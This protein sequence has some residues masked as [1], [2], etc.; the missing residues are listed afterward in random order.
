VLL[1]WYGLSRGLAPLKALQQ[2]IRDRSPDDLSPIDAKAAPEEIA[3]LVDA[4]NDLLERLSENVGAQKRFIA[5]A[6]HQLK[7]PLA[8]LRT[9]SELALREGDPSELR[10]AL[11]QIARGSSRT[12]HLVNQ[13]LALARME[14][15][16]GGETLGPIDLAA[17]AREAVADWVPAAIA[18]G[19]DLGFEV[20]RARHDAVGVEREARV[21]V[22]GH[23]LLLG[24]LANNLVDNALRYTPR[25]GTVT[26]RVVGDG[27][28]VH[29]EVEDS[30]TGVPEAER[31]LVFERFY[32]VLGTGV[33]G[34]G[35]GLAI[36]REIAARHG[37]TVTIEDARPGHDPPGARFAVTFPLS[38]GPTA[39]L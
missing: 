21:D 29:L 39:E 30:G 35:L 2:G 32:R 14:N 12:A 8:G 6:A 18:R 24:E 11:E 25:G 27:R 13:L 15:L 20:E 1:V 26:V 5:D 23:P 22:D 17:F 9:Q 36:V 28:R 7:T 33:D 37:A 31:A 4:F 16:R 38:R 10:R 3:P 34:S 19:I